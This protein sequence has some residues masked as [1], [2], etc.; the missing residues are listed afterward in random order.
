M[1]ATIT[2]LLLMLSLS[3]ITVLAETTQGEAPKVCPNTKAL[4]GMCMFVGSKTG[5]SDPQGRYRW[6]YQ[7]KLLDAACVDFLLDSEDEIGRKIAKVWNDN[8][9]K[10]TCNSTSFDV[11]DGSLIKFAV[12][13]KFDE[14]IFDI[15]AWGVELNKVD[16]AD[17]RTVLDYVRDS[18][19]FDIG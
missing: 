8:D 5:A 19:R 3:P 12:N 14:F 6:R 9:D 4:R 1:K 17:G 2:G 15:A 11:P 13:M 10:L 18:I 16:A 7:E